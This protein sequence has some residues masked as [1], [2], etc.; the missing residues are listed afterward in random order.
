VRARQRGSGDSAG[1]VPFNPRPHGGHEKLLALA[2]GAARVLDVG[3]STGYLARRLAESG[4]TVVGVELDP[5][6]ARKAREWCADIV[7]GDVETVALPFEA[8]SFDIILCG[9]VLEHLRDPGAFLIRMRPL[10]APGGRLVLATPNVANWSM[11]VALLFGRWRYSDRGILDRSHLHLF[12]HATLLECLASAGY[13]VVTFDFTVP[14][15][16]VGTPRAEKIA[17]AVGRVR[18]SLFAYQFVVEAVAP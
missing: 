12:T 13:R 1:Y 9:D 6:A 18:P 4:S 7:V 16:L 3:C 15:P 10:L 17:H 5:D 2:R 11:R 14:V 8:G